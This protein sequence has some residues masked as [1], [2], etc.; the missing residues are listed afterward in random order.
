[1]S[2]WTP[3]CNGCTA[4]CGTGTEQRTRR[5]L[6]LPWS[7]SKKITCGDKTI[8]CV[9]GSPD[10]NMDC[11]HEGPKC[12]D[13]SLLLYIKESGFACDHENRIQ[14]EPCNL[15]ICVDGISNSILECKKETKSNVISLIF[16]S[17]SNFNLML[18]PSN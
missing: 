15:P 11:V 8:A 1:M 3:W 5:R 14:R 12:S 18:F 9:T 16:N 10:C 6:V 7:S 2:E 17:T 13:G 4:T